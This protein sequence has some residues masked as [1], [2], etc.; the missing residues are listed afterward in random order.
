MKRKRRRCEKKKGDFLKK[1][2][3]LVR[4]GNEERL[5]MAVSVR[6]KQRGVPLKAAA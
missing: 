2:S 6:A 4:G 1:I 5:S 3:H